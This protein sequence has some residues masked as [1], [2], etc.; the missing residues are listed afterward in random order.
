[1]VEP[2]LRRVIQAR[3]TDAR[4]RRLFDAGDICQS[5][6]GS[7]FVRAALGQYELEG[8]D[9]LLRLLATM[10][11]NKLADKARRPGVERHDERRVPVEAVPDN[12]LAASGETPSHQVA[13]KELVDEARRRLTAEE[14]QLLAWRAEGLDW[15]AIAA[16]LGGSP[17]ALRKRLARAV[18]LVTRQLGLDEAGP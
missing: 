18:D 16:R 3:L 14:R 10:A 12:A 4:L 7:F 11:R 17:E 6:L 1:V 13:L 8:P 5:V 15:A 2:A 9:D